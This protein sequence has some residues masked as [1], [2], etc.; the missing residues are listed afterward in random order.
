MT[1]SEGLSDAEW[2]EEVEEIAEE[3]GYFSPLGDDHIAVFVDAD[4]DV[5][6]VSFEAMAAVRAFG[7]SGLPIG[8]DIADD[9]NW[10]HLS[11]V[12]I[13]ESWFRDANVFDFFDRAIDDGFFDEFETV[14]F[15][16]AGACAYAAAVFSVAAPGAT[17]LLVSP[18]ATLDPAQAEWDRRFPQTRR[19]AL[20][21]R[22]SYAPDMLEAASAAYV[23]YDP[24]ET[25]DA[26]HASLFRGS[27]IEKIRYRR[28]RSGSIDADFRALGILEAATDA[29]TKG[30]L[31]AAVFWQALRIRKHHIPYL[32][33][34]LARVQRTERPWLTAMLCR[35]VLDEYPIPRFRAILAQAEEDIE[36]QN[37]GARHL[38]RADDA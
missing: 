3:R 14:I 16:G 2:L 26:M 36:A 35:A 38:S 19:C 13:E 22:F 21:T 11:L 7:E 1:L 27:H 32:R 17:V 8:F 6:F 34:L 31:N 20:S 30:A 24:T 29:A 5:L 12:S 15:Y 4:S 18:Q 23:I 28:G 9:K 33:G 10:S 37:R 25:V